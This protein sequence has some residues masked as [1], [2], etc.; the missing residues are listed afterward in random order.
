MMNKSKLLALVLSLVMAFSLA[1]CGGNSD[2]DTTTTTTEAA[3]KIDVVEVADAKLPDFTVKIND[4]EYKNA[5]FA[6]LKVYSIESTATNKSGEEITATYVGYKL[7]DIC[8][9][10]ELDFS[11][12]IAAVA[13]DGYTMDYDKGQIKADTTLLAIT[14]DD[15]AEKGLFVAPCAETVANLYAKM[16]TTITVK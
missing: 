6:T 10:L 12:G 7:K 15:S 16:V 8:D 14:K 2:A 4:K 1:A 5:D 9:L 13:S 11:N 3:A